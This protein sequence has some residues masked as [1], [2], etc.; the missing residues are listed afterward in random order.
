LNA[1]VTGASRGIGASIARRLAGRG[2]RVALHY[3]RDH[4]SAEGVLRSAGKELQANR[5]DVRI[6]LI[7]NSNIPGK[8]EINGVPVGRS[9]PV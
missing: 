9:R 7:K 3:C 6:C 4:D 2:A 5:F 8:T 1:L